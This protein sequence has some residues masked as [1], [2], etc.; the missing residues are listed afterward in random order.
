MTRYCTW[1]LGS[2]L[3]AGLLSSP[4]TAQENWGEPYSASQEPD[5]GDDTLSVT[6]RTA[7]PIWVSTNDPGDW[8]IVVSTTPQGGAAPI[9][10]GMARDIGLTPGQYQVVSDGNQIDDPIQIVGGRGYALELIHQPNMPALAFEAR[11]IEDGEGVVVSWSGQNLTAPS[12]VVEERTTVIEEPAPP[13]RTAR[14]APP[15]PTVV[16]K[17]TTVVREPAP[18]P[19]TVVSRFFCPYHANVELAMPGP[20]P[21]CSTL[22][23]EKQVEVPAGKVIAYQCQWHPEVISSTPTSCYVCRAWMTQTLLDVR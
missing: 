3:V 9:E 2:I 16:E 17:R 5:P 8:D 11:L 10:P 19:P 13:P 4:V 14:P 6:N 7:G 21:V 18:P 23:I 22:L 20:C 1:L 12:A 15:P